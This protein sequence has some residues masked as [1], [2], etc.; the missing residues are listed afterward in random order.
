MVSHGINFATLTH[1]RVPERVSPAVDDASA[2][3]E[4][5]DRIQERSSRRKRLLLRCQLSAPNP[6]PHTRHFYCYGSLSPFEGGERG[7]G[8]SWGGAS[9]F[10]AGCGPA[11]SMTIGQDLYTPGMVIVLQT[12]LYETPQNVTEVRVL[13]LR[14][15]KRWHKKPSHGESETKTPILIV[16]SNTVMGTIYVSTLDQLLGGFEKML[17]KHLRDAENVKLKSKRYHTHVTILYCCGTFFVHTERSA[18]RGCVTWVQQLA[19][20]KISLTLTWL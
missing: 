14:F 7:K 1:V 15:V 9:G 4:L 2:S 8:C 6:I 12:S 3:T 18:L 11:H 20:I 19:L 16:A 17:Q 10:R 5:R 13:C